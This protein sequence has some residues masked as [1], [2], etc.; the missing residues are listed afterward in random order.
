[1]NL[2]VIVPFYNE[3]KFLKKSVDRLLDNELLRK[4]E[5][6]NVY[7]GNFFHFIITNIFEPEPKLLDRALVHHRIGRLRVSR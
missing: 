1:M 3:E 2:A 6:N 5:I 4:Y 7:D